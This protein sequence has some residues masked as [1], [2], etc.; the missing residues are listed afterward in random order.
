[1]EETEDRDEFAEDLAEEDKVDPYFSTRV[2]AGAQAQ[3][4][5]IALV[6]AR[7]AAGISAAEMARRLGTSRGYLHKLENRIIDPGFSAVAR[8]AAIVGYEVDIR[9]AKGKRIPNEPLASAQA[10]VRRRVAAG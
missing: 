6:E 4:S 10:A 1:M 9:R 5:I 8:Y 2:W 7:Q 3:A